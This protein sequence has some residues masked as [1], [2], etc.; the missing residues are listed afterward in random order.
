VKSWITGQAILPQDVL[1]AVGSPAHGAV[2]LFLGTVREQN[3]GQPVRGM[4]YDAYAEM[5]EAVLHAIL[6]EAAEVAGSDRIAA[7]HRTGELSI[8][9]VSVAIAVSTPHRAQA[10]AAARHVIEQIKLR[11]PVWK[12]EHYIQGASRWLG[13]AVP[14]VSR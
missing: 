2:L 10:F 6:T 13:G 1:D 5:A 9:E 8:G 3:E 11:L 14:P 4:R 12:H 7:V